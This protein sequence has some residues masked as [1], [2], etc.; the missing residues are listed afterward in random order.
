MWKAKRVKALKLPFPFSFAWQGRQKK[1]RDNVNKMRRSGFLEKET[2]I[3]SDSGMKDM[4]VYEKGLAEA[5]R[6]AAAEY[7]KAL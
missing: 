3:F 2:S 5:A 1:R 4:G 6:F 7:M